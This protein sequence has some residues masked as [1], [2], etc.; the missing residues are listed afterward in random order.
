MRLRQF[1]SSLA[2]AFEFFEVVADDDVPASI[3]ALDFFEVV[4]DD[5]APLS[6]VQLI[7]FE[8]GWLG[9]FYWFLVCHGPAPYCKADIQ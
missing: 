9:L 7:F 3:P 1:G 8:F 4:A 2:A 6:V 5:N